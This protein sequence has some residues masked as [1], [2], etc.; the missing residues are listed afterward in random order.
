MTD[1][2]QTV[3]RE[4]VLLFAPLAH[5]TQAT[6]QPVQR[7]FDYATGTV[8]DVP[9][10]AGAEILALLGDAGVDLQ[11][12]AAA[13]G[14]RIDALVAAGQVLWPVIAALEGGQTPGLADLSAAAQ[15]IQAA[16]RAFR[17]GL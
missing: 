11:A 16:I 1:T 4:V 17:D 8:G 10:D 15:G 2:A 9:H 3:L 12:Q 5:A 7:R 6:V 13:L 14:T